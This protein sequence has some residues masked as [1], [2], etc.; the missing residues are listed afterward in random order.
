MKQVIIYIKDKK[1]RTTEKC[2]LYSV[3]QFNDL[4]Y[5]FLNNYL[6]KDKEAIIKIGNQYTSIRDYEDIMIEAKENGMS[7]HEAI[8]HWI[9]SYEIQNYVERHLPKY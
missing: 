6:V 7:Y 4:A 3:A 9:G 5:C 2:Y 1:D 8:K